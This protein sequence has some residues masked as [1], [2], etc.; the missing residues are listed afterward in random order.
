MKYREL[1]LESPLRGGY[2]LRMIMSRKASLPEG[3][4]VI[5]AP[6][7]GITTAPFRKI[8]LEHGADLSVTEMVSSEALTRGN[9]DDCRAARGLDMGDGPL[10][11]QIFGG[12]PDRMGETA[13][14]LSERHRP[15]YIDMNFGCPV[16]KIVKGG[17]GS[18]VLR[19]RDRLARI[20]REVVR[21]S[22]VPVSAKIRAGWDRTSGEGVRD[23]AR[24]IEDAGVSMLSVHARTRTQG[25]R[26]K[27][28]WELIAHAKDAVDIPVVGNGDVLGADDVVSMQRQTGCDA[29]MIGRGAIGN[30][31]IFDEVKA[32]LA[33]RSYEPP[34]ASERVNVLLRHA[35]E[36][37][38]LEGELR[39]LI[40][41][42]KLMAAYVRF[43]PDARELRG[44]LMQ[45]ESLAELTDLLS[46]WCDEHISEPTTA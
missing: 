1:A 21:R 13:A 17:G 35:R 6:L 9:L 44:R 3:V 19:D 28:N 2:H 7:C 42:R 38:H 14:V 33:G 25:F 15:V 22:H 12:D 11:I 39:G 16:K 37:V 10:S 26:G 4:R 5:L 34:V 24:T 29:V 18:N 46:S 27:A 45:V 32:R 23:I 41:M 30:P 36:A 20:C 31:W 8:C 40:N 43:L